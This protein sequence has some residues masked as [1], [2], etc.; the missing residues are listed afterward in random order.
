[1]VIK[2]FL[3]K[4]NN[5]L[6]IYLQFISQFLKMLY[7]YILYYNILKY[8]NILSMIFKLTCWLLNHRYKL[9]FYINV[10]NIK[11]LKSRQWQI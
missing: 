6:I 2:L 9:K 4:V 1:M 5:F 7:V 11:I 3:T 10:T 8:Y